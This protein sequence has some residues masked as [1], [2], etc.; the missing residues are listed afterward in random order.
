M[1]VASDPTVLVV[2]CDGYAYQK[3]LKD[4]LEDWATQQA[5]H[6]VVLSAEMEQ[7]EW[8]TKEIRAAGYTCWSYPTNHSDLHLADKCLHKFGLAL[9]RSKPATYNE[10]CSQ[11]E[12][13]YE[14]FP[15]VF[16]QDLSDLIIFYAS[17]SDKSRKDSHLPLH[18]FIFFKTAYVTEEEFEQL[19]QSALSAFSQSINPASPTPHQ[20]QATHLP[21]LVPKP[22]HIPS[23]LPLM[24]SLLR[25]CMMAMYILPIPS[26]SCSLM[27]KIKL[28]FVITY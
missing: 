11:I 22:S 12:K 5:V 9:R 14:L 2:F 16:V 27:S 1:L 24:M 3:K 10:L 20:D 18:S 15:S 19:K 17:D 13:G 23:P 28:F 4:M 26:P 7:W 25:A 8:A 21:T 6:T